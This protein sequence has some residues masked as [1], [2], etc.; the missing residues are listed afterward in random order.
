MLVAAIAG[1][2]R[3]VQSRLLP[4]KLVVRGSCGGRG[5]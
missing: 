4:V 1:A 3:T 5:S 2:A